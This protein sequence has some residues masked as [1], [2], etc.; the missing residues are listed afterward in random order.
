MRA[1]YRSANTS[2]FL[3]GADNLLKAVGVSDQQ[4]AWRFSQARQCPWD[5]VLSMTGI[6]FLYVME[7]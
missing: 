5:E 3:L 1:W 2:Q 6:A 4:E 7:L